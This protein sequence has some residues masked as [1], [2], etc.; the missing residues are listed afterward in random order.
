MKSQ[1]AVRLKNRH[2]TVFG[3]VLFLVGFAWGCAQTV[4]SKPEMA[5]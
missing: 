2:L 3:A 4:E 5:K 1:Q